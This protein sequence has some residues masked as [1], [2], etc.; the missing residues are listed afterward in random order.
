MALA[1]CRRMVAIGKTALL[2]DELL[3][4]DDE[5]ERLMLLE[6][7]AA[8]PTPKNA[9][10]LE[11]VTRGEWSRVTERAAVLLGEMR[12]RAPAVEVA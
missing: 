6:A 3:G 5:L 1:V 10:V 12:G 2:E 8:L 4:S 7:F 11:R 9:A